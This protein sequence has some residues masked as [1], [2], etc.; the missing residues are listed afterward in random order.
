MRSIICILI[1]ILFALPAEAKKVHSVF[2]EGTD[3][4]LH[5]YKVFGKEK[6]KTILLIGGIQGDEP[7]G[8]LSADLYADM[9]LAKGN[10]IVVPRANF[11]SILL[12]QRQVNEDMNRKFA[13]NSKPNYEARVVGIL[14]GLI[15]ESDL[16]LNLHDGSGFFSETWIDDQRNPKRYGQSIIADCD[17]YKRKD[18]ETIIRLGDMARSVAT[19]INK[20][21]ASKEHYFSFNNHDTASQDSIH[22]VQR[23]SA[24]YYALTRCEIPAFGVETS[25][26]LPLELKIRHHVYA[27]NA[28]MEALEVIPEHPF[29]NLDKPE[30]KYL[31]ISVNDTLPVAVNNGHTLFL[32]PKDKVRVIHIETN[33]ERG[34][35]ADIIGFGSVSDAG[36]SIEINR[37]TRIDVKKDAYLCGSINLSLNEKGSMDK[38]VY[39]VSDKPQS[40]FLFYRVLVNG[41]PEIIDNY[42]EV[43]LV[44]GDALVIED[45]ATSICSPADLVVNFKGYVG[46]KSVN[47]G[48]DRQCR[49]D[50]ARDL[51]PRYS[52]NK[53][54]KRYQVITTANGREVGKLF[55]VLESPQFR[56]LVIKNGDDHLKCY[57][58]GETMK[59]GEDSGEVRFTV[60]DLISNVR[61]NSGI[62]VRMA[63][64]NGQVLPIEIGKPISIKRDAAGG[65][66]FSR[67][68]ITRSGKRMGELSVNQ[69]TED[70]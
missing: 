49:I 48:E 62:D 11:H 60:V 17:N 32:K 31:V 56:Y 37:Q 50:T 52:L 36:K 24:T 13:D 66:Q 19:E 41:Q 4:E 29:I 43:R 59:L 20:R 6:G 27:I 45:V 23:K 28:F 42:G 68:E 70:I 15:A 21:I 12:N 57:K 3:Y 22:K 25:K 64:A 67:M 2:F 47:T 44:A 33:Y 53:L 26:T 39:A 40:P 34:L 46:K 10:L 30:L 63:G 8:F 14:K 7:G 1:L 55:V 38:T 58:N 54:G 5:V 18:G 61:R 9:A 65:Q 69:L 35:S 51:W 16:L